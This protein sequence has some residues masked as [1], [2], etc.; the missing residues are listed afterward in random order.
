MV[1]A[2]GFSPA[3]SIG[4]SN[5]FKSGPPWLKP[6]EVPIYFAGLKPGASTI[7]YGVLRMR[8]HRNFSAVWLL[9]L[10]TVLVVVCLVVMP[11]GAQYEVLGSADTAVVNKF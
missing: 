9:H 3:K 4:T 7:S 2:P 1:E 6:F 10:L 11:S 5:C 8:T